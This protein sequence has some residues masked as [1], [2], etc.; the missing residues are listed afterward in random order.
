M[1]DLEANE[2]GNETEGAGAAAGAPPAGET[3]GRY[4]AVPLTD[5]SAVS[6]SS[7]IVVT[8]TRVSETVVVT[9]PGGD[10]QQ[11][12]PTEQLKL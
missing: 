11:L 7:R 8:E 10:G 3:T 1:E 12:P 4:E 6:H 2:E 9:Q 5:Q